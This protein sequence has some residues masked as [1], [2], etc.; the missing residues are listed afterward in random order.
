MSMLLTKFTPRRLVARPKIVIRAL[1]TKPTV[2]TPYTS[3]NDLERMEKKDN[4]L[5]VSTWKMSVVFV[6]L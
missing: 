3:Y 2:K 5:P 6:A 1:S 4:I